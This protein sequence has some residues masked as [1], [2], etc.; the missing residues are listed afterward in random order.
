MKSNHVMETIERELNGVIIRQRTCDSFYSLRSILYVVSK[1]RYENKINKEF[2][3][4]HYLLTQNVKSFLAELEAHTGQKPYISATKKTEG[5]VHPFFA[6][7]ILTHNNPK[8]EIAVYDWLF[9]SLI[10]N[11][12]SSGDSYTRMAGVLFKYAENK[13][14]FPS[15]I[16]IVAKQ[17]KDLLCVNDWNK[18]T[19]EQLKKRDYIHNMIADLAQT[20]QNST[21]GVSLGFKAYLAK[22]KGE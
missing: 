16:S 1:W 3:F 2:D 11:R 14:K 22:Y 9:D 15:N 4:Q 6:L 18:A 5:W 20:L 7:K 19:Q 21:Q 12:I 17:I 8:F 10:E 13:A